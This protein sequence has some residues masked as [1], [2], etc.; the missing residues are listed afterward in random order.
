MNTDN[1][2]QNNFHNFFVYK[3]SPAEKNINFKCETVT[4]GFELSVKKNKD[5]KD[6]NNYYTIKASGLI[7]NEIGTPN[8]ENF[9]KKTYTENNTCYLL[10]GLTNSGKTFTIF[11]SEQQKG[12]VKLL[13][14]LLIEKN[15]TKFYIVAREYDVQ[16]KSLFEGVIEEKTI[17]KMLTII[18]K[19]RSFDTTTGNMKSSRTDLVID[20]YFEEHNKDIKFLTIID[21]TGNETFDQ[22][23]KHSVKIK[24]KLT[25]FQTI[26]QNRKITF[27]C[28]LNDAAK[29]KT[30]VFYNLFCFDSNEKY[31]ER[32]RLLLKDSMKLF[33]SLKEITK[34]KPQEYFKTNFL[35]EIKIIREHLLSSKKHEQISN[36][37]RSTNQTNLFDFSESKNKLF[38]FSESQNNHD[39]NTEEL[40]Y[41][42]PLENDEY[43]ENDEN[44]YKQNSNGEN[45]YKQIEQNDENDEN[46]YSRIEDLSEVPNFLAPEPP[47]LPDFTQLHDEEN[48]NLV[49]PQLP[50]RNR[51][52]KFTDK[53]CAVQPEIPPEIPPAIP[54]RNTE[55]AD[56]SI[57]STPKINSSNQEKNL[58]NLDLLFAKENFEKEINFSPKEKV[59]QPGDFSYKKKKNENRDIDEFR[60]KEEERKLENK[61]R[62]LS[63]R[64]KQRLKEMQDSFDSSSSSILHFTD[65]SSISPIAPTPF[66]RIQKQK[67]TPSP[68]LPAPIVPAPIV[69]SPIVPSPI[70]PTPPPRFPKNVPEY[71]TKPTFNPIILEKVPK[72]INT[73]KDIL[74]QL[75]DLGIKIEII[76]IAEILREQKNLD[77]IKKLLDENST[78][79][80]IERYYDK[81]NILYFRFVFKNKFSKTITEEFESEFKSRK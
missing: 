26:L 61:R 16:T 20:I 15:I 75:K 46:I 78:I 36:S 24:K 45:P 21:F 31:D 6:E 12:L 44:S 9:V 66:P 39:L 13:L 55:F 65:T 17:E 28:A 48:S 50:K 54:Q 33:V 80:K 76:H 30:S 2:S 56:N 3:Y 10:N 23:N 43:D 58:L 14:E 40:L 63:N 64:E 60:R 8:L 57:H 25:E 47:L 38:D 42:E 69:P 74:V 70:V 22:R 37:Y 5:A 4:D 41:T 68:I 51:N 77:Y 49:P 34:T 81:S 67:P 29:N 79:L 32:K 53:D 7:L 73:Y 1:D 35:S 71:T 72:K 62:K 52:S 19:K 18:K 11:G 27:P 59:F